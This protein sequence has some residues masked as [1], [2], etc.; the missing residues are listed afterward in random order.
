M[1]PSF[2]VNFY[3]HDSVKH[4]NKEWARGSVN[5]N[6]IESVWSVF[7]RAIYGTWHHVS[8]K[9]LARYINEVSF[10]LNEGNFLSPVFAPILGVMC[11][12]FP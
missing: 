3:K 4:G 6:S 7:K 8:V 1:R 12:I 11:D 5:T 10:R 9:H 2:P